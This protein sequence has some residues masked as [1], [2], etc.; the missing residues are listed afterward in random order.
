MSDEE[1]LSELEMIRKEGE[2]MLDLNKKM[3]DNH[4]YLV[5]ESIMNLAAIK[6]INADIEKELGN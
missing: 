4:Q 2:I 1:F 3:G 5:E 6:A